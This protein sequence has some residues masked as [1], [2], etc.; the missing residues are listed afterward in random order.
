MV[1]LRFVLQVWVSL[2]LFR[3]I[4][5]SHCCARCF[6]LCS[7][8]LENFQGA[9]CLSAHQPCRLRWLARLA[10]DGLVLALPRKPPRRSSLC[11]RSRS[12][13]EHCSASLGGAWRLLR[14]TLKC[15]INK[16]FFKQTEARRRV[17]CP[18]CWRSG[19]VDAAHVLG[20]APHSEPD[21]DRCIPH[22]C[23]AWCKSIAPACDL[24]PPRPSVC[25][26]ASTCA[27]AFVTAKPP[28]LTSSCAVQ[29]PMGFI[30]PLNRQ[31]IHIHRPAQYPLL[32][33]FELFA[34]VV[35]CGQPLR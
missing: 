10:M 33:R 12:W 24:L 3:F 2:L 28:A 16:A 25:P 31:R 8:T 35:Q 29:P 23:S 32:W 18:A 30:S 14:N 20:I 7:S 19:T 21:L 11:F 22:P 13:L 9:H 6:P 15:L 1:T 26:C 5:R 4:S 17:A 27:G 34:H